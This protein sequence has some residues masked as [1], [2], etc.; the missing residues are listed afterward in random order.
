MVHVVVEW[1]FVAWLTNC[2][3][4]LPSLHNSSVLWSTIN[5]LI[6]T[7]KI[8]SALGTELQVHNFQRVPFAHHFFETF[9]GFYT[10][11]LLCRMSGQIICQN[12]EQ[13]RLS[14]NC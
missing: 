9:D 6:R 10:T 5:F 3:S 14:E 13:K 12:V 7:V 1:P 2:K 11:V 8:W 4:C